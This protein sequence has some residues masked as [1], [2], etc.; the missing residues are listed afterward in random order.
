VELLSLP[1]PLTQEHWDRHLAQ[2][3]IDSSAREMKAQTAR[4][5]QRLSWVIIGAVVALAAQ[6][7]TP[8]REGV[9][10]WLNSGEGVYITLRALA[11]AAV[12]AGLTVSLSMRQF[13]SWLNIACL[14]LGANAGLAMLL[15]AQGGSN[16]FPFVIG[17]G[18]ALTLVTILC[19][20]SVGAGVRMLAGLM[21][22][23]GSPKTS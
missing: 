4:T 6:P 3:S 5:V 12:V 20:A 16:I 15:F 11:I 17:V 2:I 9:H 23:S 13:E 21:V 10:W 19:G 22:R 8:G 1:T 14:W 18:G 7:Y